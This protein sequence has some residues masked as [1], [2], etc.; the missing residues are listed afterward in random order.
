MGVA[1]DKDP[2]SSYRVEEYRVRPRYNRGSVH[3]RQGPRKTRPNWRGVDCLVNYKWV[4]KERE[5]QKILVTLDKL[6]GCRRPKL[7]TTL[8]PKAH[9]RRD[10]QVEN[11]PARATSSTK[12][13]DLDT[14]ILH[15]TLIHTA[16]PPLMRLMARRPERPGGLIPTTFPVGPAGSFNRESRTSGRLQADDTHLLYHL[17]LSRPGML[18]HEEAT[19]VI[20]RYDA[21]TLACWLGD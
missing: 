17:C 14:W 7:Y 15:D 9:E 19:H 8:G 16:G 20:A 1:E 5:R 3:S 10:L 6:T 13:P 21:C 2:G 4:V 12:L 11:I 18:S